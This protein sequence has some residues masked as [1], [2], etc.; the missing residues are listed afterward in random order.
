L[1]DLYLTRKRPALPAYRRQ[2]IAKGLDD[3]AVLR[4]YRSILRWRKRR[5]SNDMTTATAH[6]IDNNI[7]SGTR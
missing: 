5:G 3:A 6:D 1:Q 7:R 2:L 4:G